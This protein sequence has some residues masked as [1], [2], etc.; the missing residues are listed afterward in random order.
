M[1]NISAS[2]CFLADIFA[3]H[4]DLGAH[5]LGK[6]LLVVN[7]ITCCVIVVNT[8]LNKHVRYLKSAGNF[9]TGQADHQGRFQKT[10]PF[11]QIDSVTTGKRK[12]FH[13]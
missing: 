9:R 1:T 13:S 2:K 10:Q 8:L 4:S 3:V 5:P 7:L 12:F 11:K 6:Q